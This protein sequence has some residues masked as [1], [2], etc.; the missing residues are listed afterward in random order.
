MHQDRPQVDSTLLCDD[1]ESS[2]EDVL[3]QDTEEKQPLR[4]LVEIFPP[5]LSG[6]FLCYSITAWYGNCTVADKAALQRMVKAAQKIICLP[7]TPLEDI[8]RALC[9]S[10]ASRVLTDNT[11]PC[12]HLFTLLTS[13]RCY[14][15][16]KCCTTSRKNSF[17]PT[18]IHELN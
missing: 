15:A 16:L 7:L 14:R 13:G 1:E 18:A 17:Y 4:R 3:S 11:H 2:T 5:L 12:H 9:H 8:Y 10:R 6:E